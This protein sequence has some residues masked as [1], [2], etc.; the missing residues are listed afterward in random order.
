[1]KY[2]QVY[3]E[4][5]YDNDVVREVLLP[6]GRM[7]KLTAS[8]IREIEPFVMFDCETTT[9]VKTRVVFYDEVMGDLFNVAKSV[10]LYDVFWNCDIRPVTTGEELKAL[11]LPSIVELVERLPDIADEDDYNNTVEFIGFCEK[12]LAQCILHPT[13]ELEVA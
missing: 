1:M 6:Y 12:L 11:L 13:A 2:I 4:T 8:Q 10:D 5:N 3:L 7:V 9:V